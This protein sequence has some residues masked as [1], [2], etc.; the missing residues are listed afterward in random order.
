M[1]V[2]VVVVVVV[3]LYVVRPNSS[4]AETEKWP[5]IYSFSFYSV[6]ASLARKADLKGHFRLSFSAICCVRS[7]MFV[8]HVLLFLLLLRRGY[9]LF[10][11][12]FVCLF[13]LVITSNSS[14]GGNGKPRWPPPL[15]LT[16]YLPS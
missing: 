8:G 10:V 9:C 16:I 13:G 4:A 11:G 6:Q 14:D 2:V 12:R 15:P 1:M 7:V 5:L 3:V